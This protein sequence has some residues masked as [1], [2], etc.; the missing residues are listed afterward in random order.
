MKL[1]LV[2]FFKF[3]CQ[4]VMKLKINVKVIG[5]KKEL[6][7]GKKRD[8][9]TTNLMKEN[10]DKKILRRQ[11]IYKAKMKSENNITHN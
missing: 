6:N 2:R 11:K 5:I 9:K 3:K 4:N 8:A 1:D 7:A 10:N